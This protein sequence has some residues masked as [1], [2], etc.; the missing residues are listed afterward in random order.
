MRAGAKNPRGVNLPRGQIGTGFLIYPSRA[1]TRNV[2]IPNK[3]PH[4]STLS[5][6]HK[7]SSVAGLD[8]RGRL[9]SFELR[10]REL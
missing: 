6:R 2:D 9:G 3:R 1:R 4:L 5:H 8:S 10:S 7:L